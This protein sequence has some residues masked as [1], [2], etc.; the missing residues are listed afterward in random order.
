MENTQNYNQNY[1]QDNN[2]DKEIFSYTYS[3]KQQEE[4]KKIR[5][6]YLPPREDKMEQLRRMD[7]E[8]T[9]KATRNSLII[10]II[11]TLIMGFGMSLAMSDIGTFLHL[12]RGVGMSA[13]ILTG[14]AGMIILALAYPVYLRTVKKER[15]KIAPEILRLTEE[16]MK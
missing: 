12:S 6:R 14:I 7:A 5:D 11:G 8:V 13:G 3:A 15:A 10:G 1:N 2:Q 16:L 9:R 4:I